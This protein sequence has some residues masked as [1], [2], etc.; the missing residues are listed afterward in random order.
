MISQK[1]T[2]E[3]LEDT[4]WFPHRY[5]IET[6]YLEMINLNRQ[7]IETTTFLASPDFPSEETTRQLVDAKSMGLVSAPL[8]PP[9]FI[10]HSAFCCSTLIARAMDSPGKVR[11][12]KEPQITMDIAAHIRRTG[13]IPVHIN[14]IRNLLSRTSIVGERTVIKPTNMANNLLLH[15]TELL[16]R[17]PILFL[18]GSLRGFLI[19][20]LKKGEQ[21]RYMARRMYSIFRNDPTRFK[22]IP[23]KQVATLTDLQIAAMVWLLQIEIFEEKLLSCTDGLMASLHCDD[24]LVQPIGYLASINQHLKL[25]LT[26]KELIQLSRSDIL[27]LDSKQQDKSYNSEKRKAESKKVEDEYGSTLDHICNWADGLSLHD[28]IQH[29]LSRPIQPLD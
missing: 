16:S 24:F 4:K 12:L 1:P 11:S 17:S 13:S 3:L 25:S 28:K 6:G 9:A 27:N 10:F 2:N 29:K 21:G 26:D 23:L 8:S 18:Y 22:E 7:T 19:S 5:N 15:S 20:V 14:T